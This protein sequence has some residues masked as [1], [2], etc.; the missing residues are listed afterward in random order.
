MKKESFLPK[1]I[2]NNSAG[3]IENK[4]K[5]YEAISSLI[6]EMEKQYEMD[7]VY[8]E[9]KSPHLDINWEEVYEKLKNII[10]DE[11]LFYQIKSIIYEEA[12]DKS[13]H[14]VPDEDGEGNLLLPIIFWVDIKDRVKEILDQNI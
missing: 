6:D 13:K 10:G 2:E 8:E 3:K 5:L 11:K 9:G 1:S 14:G 4:E 12:E 7:D